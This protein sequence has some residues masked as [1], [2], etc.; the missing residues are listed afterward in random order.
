MQNHMNDEK[1]LYY[2][3][4]KMYVALESRHSFFGGLLF[5]LVAWCCF[6]PF[7]LFWLCYDNF[8]SGLRMFDKPIFGFL[9]SRLVDWFLISLSFFFFL[10][11]CIL[12]PL[13]TIWKHWPKRMGPNRKHDCNI[14]IIAMSLWTRVH[15]NEKQMWTGIF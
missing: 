1:T 11:Y 4:C 15:K 7:M 14:E 8:S 6:R 3:K 12:C 9:S 5:L 13:S 10:I 2:S